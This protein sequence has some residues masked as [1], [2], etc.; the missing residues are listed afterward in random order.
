LEDITLSKYQARKA[1]NRASAYNIPIEPKSEYLSNYPPP[2]GN[3]PEVD[4]VKVL[5]SYG[6]FPAIHDLC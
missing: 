6:C 2:K 1:Y 3:G 4:Y 5:K